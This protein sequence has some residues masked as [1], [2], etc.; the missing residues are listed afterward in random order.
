[1][2]ERQQQVAHLIALGYSIDDVAA[3][4]DMHPGSVKRHL[5]SL[6]RKYGLKGLHELVGLAVATGVVSVPELQEV[7]CNR[8]NLGQRSV[9]KPKR[10]AP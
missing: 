6:Y 5:V 2:T 3:R 10:P 7:Y 1:M 9:R 4:L 8:G